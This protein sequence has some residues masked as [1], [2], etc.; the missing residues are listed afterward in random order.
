MGM[1]GGTGGG[2]T[3]MLRSTKPGSSHGVRI[4]NTLQTGGWLLLAAVLAYYGNGRAD[5]I[6]LLLHSPR[7][8][9][10]FVNVAFAALSL[11]AA[12]FI[13]MAVWLEGVRRVPDAAAAVPWLVPAGAVTFAITFVS[14]I[15]GLWPV[16]SVLA[17]P[18]VMVETI[19]TVVALQFVPTFGIL[20][21]V[22]KLD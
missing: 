11:N 1:T 14:F 21:A 7:L 9:R 19:G 22:K 18:L 3:T 15:V 10:A 20:R 17:L 2:T 6:T 13:Y 5:L 12:L 16:F 8:N 4:V